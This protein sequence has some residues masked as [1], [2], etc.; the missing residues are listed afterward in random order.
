M[1]HASPLVIRLGCRWVIIRSAGLLNSSASVGH[2]PYWVTAS[3]QPHRQITTGFMASTRFTLQVGVC[4]QVLVA[5]LLSCPPILC[6]GPS[7]VKR[8]TSLRQSAGDWVAYFVRP[9]PSPSDCLRS[10]LLARP[11]L[12]LCKGQAVRPPSRASAVPVLVKTIL[13]VAGCCSAGPASGGRCI[14]PQPYWSSSATFA[15]SRSHG[16]CGLIQHPA[17]CLVGALESGTPRH[18]HL[19]RYIMRSPVYHLS[20]H[21]ARQV[22]WSVDVEPVP[23]SCHFGSSFPSCPPQGPRV[24]SASSWST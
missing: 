21:P 15:C 3:Y 22:F 9:C 7:Q 14:R 23:G 16:L 20:Q 11:V 2:S 12:S 1:Q 18:H 4:W 13:C 8:G 17:L 10:S 5:V 6:S 24:S 19:R